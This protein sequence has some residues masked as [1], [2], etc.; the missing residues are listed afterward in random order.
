[1]RIVSFSERDS[2][3]PIFNNSIY[4]NKHLGWFNLWQLEKNEGRIFLDEDGPGAE[5]IVLQPVCQK[6]LWLHSF[7]SVND[8]ENYD[9]NN[10]LKKCLPHG[11]FSV[12]SISSHTWYSNLLKKNGFRQCD[13][14]I[15]M[16]TGQIRSSV[17]SFAA[18]L[19]PIKRSD[20]LPIYESCEAAFPPIWQLKKAEFESAC[21]DAEYKMFISRSGKVLGYIL[22]SISADNCHIMRLCVNPEYLHLGIASELIRQLTAE[23]SIK[24]I[25]NFSVNTNEKN[26]AAV[27]LYQSLNFTIS[28][29][30]YPVFNR[31]IYSRT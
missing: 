25:K 23:C 9:L 28:G 14:I 17:H 2:I 8:P 12:Y 27:H 24:G 15:Q 22:A 5:M 20:I 4:L 16:E 6:I 21:I 31:Q 11:S 26:S 29:K 30:T 3:E 7:L 18:S 1:M 19:Y 13:A 10:A